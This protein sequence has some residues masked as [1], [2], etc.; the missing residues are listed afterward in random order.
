[1][2]ITTFRSFVFLTAIL[3]AGIED[4]RAQGTAFVYQG[5]L[6]NEG[7]PANGVYDFSFQVFNASSG[8]TPVG[9]TLTNVGVGVTNGLF[10][11]TLDFGPVFTGATLWLSIGVRTNGPT[12]FA[13]LS[14]LQQ[15]SP[16]PYAIFSAQAASAASANSISASNIIGTFSLDLLPSS[17]V[18]NG[19]TDVSLA[20]TFTG[21]GGSLTNLSTAALEPASP[22]P[23]QTNNYGSSGTYY[24]T[25]PAGATSLTAK[26]WGAGGVG[27]A[28]CN[29]GAGAFVLVT[30]SVVPGETLVVVVGQAGNSPAGGGGSANDA[31]GGPGA[32]GN[33]GGGGQASSLFVLSNGFYIM[34][35]VAGG[36]G[37]GGGDLNMDSTRANAGA[38]G[39][40][41]QSP[42]LTSNVRG[43]NNGSG[44]TGLGGIYNGAAY[45]SLAMNAGATN[46]DLMGG[47]GGTGA[48]NDGGGG[49]GFGGGC[50]GSGGSGGAGGGS[51][52][53]L[54]IGGNYTTPGNANDP[55]HGTFSGEPGVDGEVVLIFNGTLANFHGYVQATG[56]VGDGSALTNLTGSNLAGTIPLAALPIA[57]VTNSESAVT[58]SGSFSGNGAGLTNLNTTNFTG[59]ISLASLPTAVVTTNSSG[60]TLSGTFSG[61]GTGLTN[62]SATNLSGPVPLASLPAAVVTNN[63][64]TVTLSGSFGGNG[65]G[66]TNLNATNF[67]GT[68]SL[69][70]L[71]TAVVTT[72][73][74]AV[75]LS[76]TFSGNGAGLTALSPTAFGSSTVGPFQTN[77]YAANGTYYVTVP[78]GATSLTAKLWGAGGLGTAHC[79]GG[80]GAFVLVTNQVVAGETL[81]LVVGQ[82]G[83]APAGGGGS[84]NDAC[85]GPGASGNLG[86]GGQASSLFVL[87][88]GV[89]IMQGVAGGGGGGG[90][91]F[92]MDSST[93]NAGAGGNPGQSPSLASNVRGGNSGAGGTGLAGIYNGAAYY[94]LATNT[95]ATNLD[96]MGGDGGSGPPNDGGGGGGY[97]GGCGGSGGSGGAGGGSYGTLIIGGNFTTPG[98]ANDPDHGTF[99][100]EPAVDG[101]VVLIFSGS[102]GSFAPNLPTQAIGAST[103]GNNPNAVAVAGRYAY[104]ANYTGRNLQVIDVSTPASPTVL[105]SLTT[106]GN[107]VAVAVAG[108]YAALVYQNSTT[109]EVVDVSDPSSPVSVGTVP[110]GNYP[111]AV[112]L[113]GRYAYV[114]NHGTSLLN[115]VDLGQPSMPVVLATNSTDSTPY[116][117]AVAGRY[118]YVACQ[119][120]NTMDI[121]DVSNPGS[122][123][124]TGVALTHTNANSVAVSGRYAYV[125][126]A[127]GMLDVVDVGNPASPSVVGS[128]TTGNNPAA[129]AVAGRYAYV[130]NMNS[131]SFSVVDISAPSSPFVAGSVA[132]GSG[133][134]SVAVAGRYA[135][136][137][138]YNASLLQVFDMGGAYIQQLEA[139]ALETGTLQTRDTVS[140]GN[141]LDVRGGFTASASARISGNMEV[142]SNLTVNGAI[143]CTT[144]TQTSD[145]NA[146]ENFAPVSPMNVLDKLAALTITTWNFKEIHDSRHM[147]PMAQD[148]HATFGLNGGDETHI[149]AVDEEGVALAAIQGLNQKLTEK[150]TEIRVLQEKA[151]RVDA[152]E[153]KVNELTRL[154]QN[155]SAR[156]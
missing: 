100:G 129:V 149:A 144:L 83:S 13:A 78:A 111:Q 99:S 30:N 9:N 48:P 148:F 44:G 91:S 43:G 92:N 28:H 119:G 46:L 38:G 29:G 89:Y 112:A 101:E 79:S 49:G 5:Q 132:T 74:G 127:S 40:P 80:A 58:L 16:T 52:G 82:A 12:S 62:L 113:S 61:N 93:A 22:S 4:M 153:Q 137:V 70:S 108:R 88:N 106:V 3:T 71:P 15:I 155:L 50:G 131:S 10:A 85:G 109:L 81:V 95:G 36:G 120:T 134:V 42:S 41:G 59:T 125:G 145:R 37:G 33:L 20:G 69:A 114:V 75:T 124:E 104:S 54:I 8:G 96:L 24:V 65:A 105:G 98:N 27:T 136:V 26:V 154:V 6:Q 73:S 23:F 76:G 128:V 94:S 123:V 116:A 142:N 25:V 67:T 34:Q 31:C 152:L 87:S 84:A 140:V 19:S 14:P 77:N 64:S 115:V 56:F 102:T 57:V 135:Y 133:P 2:K 68:I 122:P 156:K 66:L 72:N 103:T 63:E 18:T 90:A 17:V 45:Y 39:N 126:C 55:D 51:Y 47:D 147:G 53:N 138:D 141:N 139:G 11:T 146:K 150:D 107:P 121:F 117:V 86:G 7:G 35:G 21:D 60:V 130:A 110:L 118:V 151:A 143:T 97:G 1:M 32:G